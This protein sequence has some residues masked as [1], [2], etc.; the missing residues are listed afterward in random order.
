MRLAR[1]VPRRSSLSF[2]LGERALWGRPRQDGSYTVWESAHRTQTPVLDAEVRFVP[3]GAGSRVDV[4]FHTAWRRHAITGLVTIVFCAV[5]FSAAVVWPL[6]HRIGAANAD[7]ATVVA[8]NT[9][10][11]ALLAKALLAEI[12]VSGVA[13]ALAVLYLVR[14]RGPRERRYVV[15]RLREILAATS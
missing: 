10:L 6:L 12:V 3:V 11:A 9:E 15:G 2:S 8:A 13:I 4:A 1:E 7:M 14:R 5:F